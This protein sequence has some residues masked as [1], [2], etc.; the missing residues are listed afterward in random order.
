MKNDGLIT[1]QMGF[2]KNKVK[3][4]GNILSK[5]KNKVQSCAAIQWIS[6]KLH[7]PEQP[8]GNT[9]CRTS[10][11][12]FPLLQYRERCI[13]YCIMIER[14]ILQYTISHLCIIILVELSIC[15]PYASYIT[16][17]FSHTQLIREL[18][19]T[20]TNN[21]SLQRYQSGQKNLYN[22][23]FQLS[24]LKHNVRQLSE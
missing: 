18:K 1:N 13:T 23:S 3:F 14:S 16:L 10:Q 19:L 6:A 5:V 9:W 8:G 2:Q 7:Q 17:L 21:L 22:M 4:T 20:C 24:R 15:Q 11:L 12:L